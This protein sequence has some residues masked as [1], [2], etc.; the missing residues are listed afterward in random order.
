MQYL[1]RWSTYCK[2]NQFWQLLTPY[3]GYLIGGSRKKD[4][5]DVLKSSLSYKLKYAGGMSKSL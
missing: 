1:K 5:T 3:S 4:M 2:L